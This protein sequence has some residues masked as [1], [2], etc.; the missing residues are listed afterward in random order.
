[1]RIARSQHCILSAMPICFVLILIAVVPSAGA[2]LAPYRVPDSLPKSWLEFQIDWK[3][4][5]DETLAVNGNEELWKQ[6][7]AKNP[8]LQPSADRIQKFR[9]I[10]LLE[11]MIGHFPKERDK[12]A[13]ACRHIADMY[14]GLGDRTRAA[15]WF[16]KLAEDNAEDSNRA[17]AYAG[18]LRV[19]DSVNAMPAV[20]DWVEYAVSGIN[21]MIQS[22]TLLNDHATAVLARQ[23]GYATLLANRNHAGAR[24]WLDRWDADAKDVR[25]RLERASLLEFV[26][27]LAAAADL[28]AAAGDKA[29]ADG[30]RAAIQRAKIDGVGNPI[31]RDLDIRWN[32]IGD[33]QKSNKSI[34]E[35]PGLVQQTLKLAAESNSFWQASPSHRVQC[36][37][38]IDEALRKL[39]PAEI[40]PFRQFQE[41]TVARMLAQLGPVVDANV[42]DQ[43]FRNY[44]WS[45]SV[46]KILVESG[47]MSL[48]ANRPDEAFRAFQNVLTHSDDPKIL[49]QARVGA[50]FAITELAEPSDVLEEAMAA[51]PDGTKLSWRD[52]EMPASEVKGILR[53]LLPPSAVG[54]PVVGKLP[55]LRIELPAALAADAPAAK[56]RNAAPQG[57]SALA[58][59]RI[60]QTEGGLYFLG[61]QHVASYD[62]K[63]FAFRW[64]KVGNSILDVPGSPAFPSNDALWP[65]GTWRPA[66]LGSRRST[67]VG[68]RRLPHPGESV[69][70]EAIYS[71]LFHNLR[72]GTQCEVAAFD[73]QGGQVLWHTLTREDWRDLEPLSEPTA[74]DGRVYVVTGSNRPD[75]YLTVF[76]TCLEGETGETLWRQPLGNVTPQAKEQKRSLLSSAV[77]LYR[78]SVYVSTNMGI[79]ARCNARDGAV[80]WVRTYEGIDQSQRP[81]EQVRREGTSPLVVGDH[82]FVA[83]RDHSGVIA[84]DRISGYLLWDVALVPSDQIVGATS[85]SLIVRGTDEL[86][87]LDVATG[88]ELWV[89]P[90]RESV[91]ARTILA[92][93]DIFVI[94]ADKLLRLAAT[95]GD[96][97]EE[98]PLE[99]G[100]GSAHVLL[101]DGTLIQ[102]S[103]AQPPFPSQSWLT[104]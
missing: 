32:A 50:W 93:P 35:D 70:P 68:K 15:N 3:P 85:G 78:G 21:T 28:Y 77:T 86:A 98:L 59:R 91:G 57:L 10:W 55:R 83:P 95:T 19:A 54:L 5:W 12:C 76:L 92:G 13:A 26:G 67:S 80:E 14:F 11:Q 34:V 38:A 48:R 53:K 52:Q 16:K 100:P 69:A 42:A 66:A 97:V 84:I 64:L 43:W 46:H 8:A 72:D 24:R 39:P 71:L 49:G 30:L 62:P 89:K 99:R 44:P 22:G 81:L 60:E 1:V 104:R 61:P 9:R 58:V 37:L 29:K 73:A 79:L 4:S 65:E 82:V 87:A 23:R 94:T 31:S 96:F 6:V 88:K 33:K 18:I 103:I 36:W 2:T 75:Q 56:D 45:A 74:A 25:L 51:V 90:V 17:D 47:E 41:A 102:L 7:V 101:A 63:T 40:I 20:A 27:N